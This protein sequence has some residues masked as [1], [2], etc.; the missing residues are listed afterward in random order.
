MLENVKVSGSATRYVRDG[1]EGRKVIYY[2]CP[3]CGSSVYWELELPDRRPG[4]LGTSGGSFFA[5]DDL[6]SPSMSVWERSKYPWISPPTAGVPDANKGLA[7]GL[8]TTSQ[9]VAVTIGIPILG[10]VMTMPGNLL[11][12]IQLALAVNVL[13]TMAAVALIRIGLSRRSCD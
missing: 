8:M 10:A 9:R 5:P 4:Q 13:L 11:G 3:T 12:G 6:P 7:T 2:F 1:Q